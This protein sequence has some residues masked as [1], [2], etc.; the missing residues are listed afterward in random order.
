[1]PSSYRGDWVPLLC[2]TPESKKLNAVSEGAELL[3]LLMHAK[4]DSNNNYYGDAFIILGKLL[5]ERMAR[6]EVNSELVDA[7]LSE[8]AKARLLVFYEA[9]GW[10]YVHFLE[11]FT[12]ERSDAKRDLRFPPFTKRKRNGTVPDTEHIGDE[13]RRDER[14]REENALVRIRDADNLPPGF[15][16]FWA[17]WPRHFRKQGRSKCVAKWEKQGFEPLADSI[18]AALRISKKSR[19]WLKNDGDFIPFPERWLNQ[20]PWETDPADLVTQ[21]SSPADKNDLGPSKPVLTQAM[22]D[23]IEAG[24]AS[25]V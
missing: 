17:E 10:R 4:A 8:L 6:G 2:S 13:K 11:R 3:Y 25:H 12:I 23:A 18:L 19:D 24:E 21:P 7:R 1:M 22:L 5:T 15:A 16:R 9:D 20:T 14:K